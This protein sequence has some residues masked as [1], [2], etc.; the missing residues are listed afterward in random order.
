MFVFLV[1]PPGTG[2]TVALKPTV[3]LQRK[4]NSCKLAPTDVSKASFLDALKERSGAFTIGSTVHDYHYMNCVVLELSN[5]M[6]DYDK[7]LA[8]LLTHI[9]DCPPDNHEEKRSSNGT[10]LIPFPGVSMICGTATENLGAT[11]HGDMWGS[12]F[13][14]RV[15]MIFS[16]D[17]KTPLDMFAVQE[18]NDKLF[19]ECI[20]DM[21]KI[22]A[23]K[24]PMAWTPEAQKLMNHF[25]HNA[26]D[27]APDHNKL[28][29]Y[30]TRRWFHLAKLCMIAALS[31]CRL[32]VLAQ[33]F[34]D[35]HTWLL[36][37]EVDMAEIFKDMIS[38]SDGEVFMDLKT[39]FLSE[40][41]RRGKKEV[42]VAWIYQFLSNRTSVN[43]IDRMIKTAEGADIIRRVAGTTGDDATYVPGDPSKRNWT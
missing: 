39:Q 14:A 31:H 4:A 32:E 43:N 27:S 19:A 2:K 35:A 37:A 36:A 10:G 13:M 9:W 17:E 6:A 38:H 3:D 21:K 40:Y 28:A 41:V 12:G 7:A 1:G 26:K 5:F 33:D 34:I 24:G 25:R 29:H 11:I 30:C 20:A 42:P 16:A 8:G 23:L 18:K 22:A 15:I